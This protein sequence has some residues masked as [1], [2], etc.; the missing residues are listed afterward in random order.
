MNSTLQYS[1][2]ELQAPDLPWAN[3]FNPS[4]GLVLF[5]GHRGLFP[6]GHALMTR[7]LIEGDSVIFVDGANFFDLPL[8]TR[9]ARE[10]QKDPREILAKVH[11]SRAFTVHQLEALILHRLESALRQYDSRLCLISGLLDTFSDEE[12]PQGPWYP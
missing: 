12:I 2:F 5:T 7:Q 6:L 10:V 11:L 3:I 1:L 9:L 8:I 4:A